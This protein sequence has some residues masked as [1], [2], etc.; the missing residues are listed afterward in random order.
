[1]GF[2]VGSAVASAA[3][4]ASVDVAVM[5][6]VFLH[7]NIPVK[8]ITKTSIHAQKRFISFLLFKAFFKNDR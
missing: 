7:A 8:S 6:S 2:A 1:V 5:L 4:G 3:F